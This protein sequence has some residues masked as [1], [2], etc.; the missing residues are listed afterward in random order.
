MNHGIPGKSNTAIVFE[1]QSQDEFNGFLLH[2]CLTK[3]QIPMTWGNCSRSTR[4]YDLFCNEWDLCGMLD[5]SS[6]PNGNWEEDHFPAV[7]TPSGPPPPPPPPPPLSS[8]MQDIENYFGCHR[9]APSLN[10]THGIERFTS[11][12][13]FHLRFQL[14][15]L[16]H[17]AHDRST[18]FEEWIQRTTWINL[19]KL[20]GDLGD[21]VE[22]VADTRKHIITC[23]IGYLVTLPSSQLSHI[24]SDLWDLGPNISLSA[25]NENIQVSYIHVSEQ[26]QLYVIQPCLSPSLVTWKLVVPDAAT[27]VTCLH[28]DWGSDIME[29]VRNLL[30][31]RIPFKT[32]QSIAVPPHAQHPLVELRT[33]SLG[34]KHPIFS[35]V[36]AD[37]VVYEQYHYEFMNQPRARAALLHGGLVWRLALHSIGFDAL[38]SVLDGISREAVPL[39]LMLSINGQTYFDDE[40]SEEVDFICGTYHIYDRDLL[41]A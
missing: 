36:Y 34:Y 12:L 37:Y 23:F 16:T 29:I 1:W 6:I 3:A 25:L 7:P 33:Y 4:I 2:I 40:L 39:G 11:I 14:T 20:I 22:L 15:A 9:V 35:A 28:H 21:N 32:L 27:A 26:Q 41:V 24:L 38:P 13:H 17:T 31:K 19:C 18:T 8:F 30:Q 10:Y 5:P